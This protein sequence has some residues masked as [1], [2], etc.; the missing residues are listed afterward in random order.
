MLFSYDEVKHKWGDLDIDY[1][2]EQNLK[3]KIARF[4]S[5]KV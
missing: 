4:L 2:E 1:T 3:K 5:R